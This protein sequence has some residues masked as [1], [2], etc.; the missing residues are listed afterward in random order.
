LS[1]DD[2]G[3]MTLVWKDQ[4]IEVGFYVSQYSGKLTLH[5]NTKEIPDAI[6]GPALRVVLND[7]FEDPLW[8]YELGHLLKNNDA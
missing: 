8:D 5:I 3:P 1:I 4:E 6:K 7:D 2:T